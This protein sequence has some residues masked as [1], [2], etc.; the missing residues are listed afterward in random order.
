[1]SDFLSRL[2]ERTL[3]LAPVA[4]PLVGSRFEPPASA[5]V[6]EVLTIEAPAEESVAA[7]EPVRQRSQAEHRGASE[8][9][10]HTPVPTGPPARPVVVRE[11]LS[12]RPAARHADIPPAEVA[13]LAFAYPVERHVR[14]AHLVEQI[15]PALDRME[16]EP[17]RTESEVRSPAPVRTREVA[18]EPQLPRR[19]AETAG[20]IRPA[21][22]HALL[23]ENQSGAKGQNPAPPRLPQP[24]EFLPLAES[25]P[26][27]RAEPE[28]NISIG[29]IE[30]RAV[31]PSANP[32]PPSDSR[33]F[34]PPL[35]LH[36]YL[37]ARRG[38]GR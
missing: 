22:G 11:E 4:K 29:R 6:E 23:T 16:P 26:G 31:S 1:M 3:G 20:H 7:M 30:V 14:T 32:K 9:K 10:T 36:D 35:S 25:D 12:A 37:K 27:S 34:V 8:L 33:R 21:S 18:E 13:A 24:Q 15:Q 19:A 2:A 17:V 38:V 5:P 28:I